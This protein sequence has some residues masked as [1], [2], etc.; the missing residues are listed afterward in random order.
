[1]PYDLP[2]VLQ[3]TADGPVRIV[4]LNRPHEM[5]AFDDDLHH[6]FASL[7]AQVERDD[8]VTQTFVGVTKGRTANTS[9]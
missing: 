5:N 4:R 8:E 6:G 7:W 1:M 9:R 2:D 3:V